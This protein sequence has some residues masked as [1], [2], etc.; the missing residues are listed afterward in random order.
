MGP[1]AWSQTGS[2]VLAVLA[3]VAG[4][5]MSPAD[6][7]EHGPE[8]RR[9]GVPGRGIDPPLTVAGLDPADGSHDLPGQA[10]A[11]GGGW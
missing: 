4:I 5:A 9:V 1:T 11:G 8:D 2:P 6:P 3:G 10:C 7:F